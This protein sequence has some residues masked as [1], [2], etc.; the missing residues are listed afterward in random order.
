MV[1]FYIPEAEDAEQA[2]E[3]YEA[4]AKF[5]EEQRAAVKRESRIRQIKYYDG[6]NDQT[7]DVSIG[8]NV[9]RVRE[10]AIA[11]FESDDKSLDVYYICTPHRAVIEGS[12]IMVGRNNVKRVEYFDE[13]SY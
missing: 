6:N 5:V 2:E 8:D 9:P 7:Y 10:P 11:I 12:P 3:V 13:D 1:E 4:T